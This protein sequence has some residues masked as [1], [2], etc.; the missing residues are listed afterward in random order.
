MK[1]LCLTAAFLTALSGIA[2]LPV[3]AESDAVQTQETGEKKQVKGAAGLL[4]QPYSTVFQLGAQPDFSGAVVSGYGT[5]VKGSETL[6]DWDIINQPL[7]SQKLDLSEIDVTKPGIYPVYIVINGPNAPEAEPI[8][9]KILEIQYVD[10]QSSYANLWLS[11]N[12]L[13]YEIGEQLDLSEVK[14]TTNGRKDGTEWA[15]SDESLGSHTEYVN[16]ADFDSTKTGEYA[17]TVSVGDQ[18]EE[19]IAHVIEAFERETGDWD[20][21]GKISNADAQSVLNV[22]VKSLTG[23]TAAMNS[24]QKKA[25]DVN[26][27]GAIDSADAQ[28]I[29]QYYV[30]NTLAGILSDWDALLK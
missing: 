6:V 27:D 26:R 23:N 13:Y 29:L 1:C 30:K 20:H 5:V 25:A 28:L 7:S 24:E 19:I 17:I 8:R 18:T 21:D 3:H 12:E 11:A 16:A 15:I 14:L 9:Q 2:A 10:D 22:Y 4:K